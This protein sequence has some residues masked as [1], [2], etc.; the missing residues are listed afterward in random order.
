MI[1]IC[2]NGIH[3]VGYNNKLFVWSKSEDNLGPE[4]LRP[5]LSKFISNR[6][7]FFYFTLVLK[8]YLYTYL[9]VSTTKATVPA[10]LRSVG[11]HFAGLE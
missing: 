4:I 8:Q 5:P 2:G 7:R 1:L 6:N 9:V 3:M 10:S 11:V